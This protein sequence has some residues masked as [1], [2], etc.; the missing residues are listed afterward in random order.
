M[1]SHEAE[2]VDAPPKARANMR[3]E[4]DEVPAVVVAGEEPALMDRAARDV[5][6]AVGEVATERSR[7]LR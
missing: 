4:A 5:V 7:H 6:D 2:R 3:E 1:R